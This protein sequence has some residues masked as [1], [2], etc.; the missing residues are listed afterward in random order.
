[1]GL[2]DWLLLGAVGLAA[3]QAWRVW[4]RTLRSG[5]C[6]CGGG[7]GGDCAHCAGCGKK[8]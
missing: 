7:C 4:R 3:A 6:G 8:K 2:L 5:G 1:M